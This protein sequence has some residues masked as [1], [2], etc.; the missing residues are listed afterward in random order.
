M[1]P[2]D[3]GLQAQISALAAAVANPALIAESDYKNFVARKALIE[4]ISKINMGPNSS[5]EVTLALN[6]GIK[7]TLDQTVNT[8]TLRSEDY[9]PFLVL[10]DVNVFLNGNIELKCTVIPANTRVYGV[11]DHAKARTPFRING[12]ARLEV[13]VKEV[14]VGPYTIPIQFTDPNG[15]TPAF[16]DPVALRRKHHVIKPCKYEGTTCISGRLIRAELPPNVI[17][18]GATGLIAFSNDSVS[19]T[20]AALTLLSEIGKATGVGSMINQSH[21]ALSAKQVFEARTTL[22]IK[23]RLPNKPLA[24]AK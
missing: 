14:V 18:G 10:E 17:S 20:V 9:V 21:A 15:N 23:V 3:P 19:N 12:R 5:S 16:R 2:A 6:T 7:L 13:Y 22:Q 24:P 4:E 8:E 11:V 1:P